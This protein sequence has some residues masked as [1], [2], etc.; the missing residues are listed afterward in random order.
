[1]R[2]LL[3]ISSLLLGTV[4]VG[5]AQE[6]IV[7]L[8]SRNLS[9]SEVCYRFSENYHI[10]FSFDADKLDNIPFDTVDSTISLSRFKA[11]LRSDYSITVNEVSPNNFYLIIDNT[12]ISFCGLVIDEFGL[13]LSEV[14]ILQDNL[15]IA[16]TDTLGKFVTDLPINTNIVIYADGMLENKVRIRDLGTD[17][18][19]I[20]LAMEVTQLD[21]VVVQEYLTKGMVKNEDSSIKLSPKD[22]GVLPGF[23]EPDIFQSLQRIP[24]VN[25]PT[26]DP[27]DLY[28]RGGTPD[29]NLVLYDGIKMYLND[30]FFKQISSYNPNIIKDVNVYRGGTSVRYGERISG[31]VDIKSSDDVFD[32]FKVGVGINLTSADAYLKIPLSDKLGILVAGRRSS[33]DLYKTFTYGKLAEKVFQ[34]SR[35]EVADLE[36]TNITDDPF[37]DYYFSDINFKT[38]WKPKAGHRLQFSFINISNELQTAN[39]ITRN[40]V[41]L[42]LDDLLIEKNLG[43]GFNW[44]NDKPGKTKKAFEAYFSSYSSAYAFNYD[45]ISDDAN[46]L[47]LYE[48]G[49]K[50][51][52]IG[53]DIFFDIPLAKKQSL[54]LGQQST[55]KVI[56]ISSLE[57]IEHSRWDEP[58]ERDFL[59]INEL[60]DLI[61]Y[62]E[63]KYKSDNLYFS[64]GLR[65]GLYNNYDDF[66]VE[67]RLYC[68]K[69]LTDKV[70]ITASAEIKNQSFSQ[71][72][73]PQSVGGLV[74]PLQLANN[75]WGIQ[76]VRDFNVA[77]LRSKQLTI[78]GLYDFNGWLVELEGYYKGISNALPYDDN[79]I[80]NLF[81]I[82]ERYDLRTGT[83]RRIG[84]DL[85]LKKRFR[86]YR[87]WLS[88]AYSVN[89]NKFAD[90]QNESFYDS[91][92]QRHNVNISQTYSYKKFEFGL[93]YSASSGLPFTEIGQGTRPELDLLI[94]RN[95][96]NKTR[97][98]EYYRW[99]IS[100]LYKF[101]LGEHFNGRA[102]F[103]ARNINNRRI[104]IKL[105]Y[106]LND[107]AG[108]DTVIQANERRSLGF[109]ADF[110]FRVNF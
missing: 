32:K 9:L 48:R 54:L 15:V 65:A 31:V 17:C 62:S 19:P 24:G 39:G 13:P 75:I 102:G 67:P 55:V 70:R 73:L 7:E 98:P 18:L 20:V 83:G 28:I 71:F 59:L 23:V 85:L 61:A 101:Q 100:A 46:A 30:H 106:A 84:M 25:S 69:K 64:F 22:L 80:P 37:V 79:F 45:Q 36:P 57:N 52:D 96:V 12:V 81:Q 95:E 68:S 4:A 104:P 53:Y 78:G 74:V 97:L 87:I 91:N 8:P 38:I 94:S 58:L 44:T 89:R 50:I 49:N 110:V 82:Q 107:T 35:L 77:I 5:L 34:N 11:I 40:N 33:T 42:K 103:A 109:I 26:E 63:Y 27:T 41:L 76:S 93:G 2:I 88:Y 51:I 56:D 108:D 47:F 92:A 6:H 21:E 14:S 3:L 10:K 99:D 43:I 72:Y 86:N 16:E 66:L 29:Q 105:D 90:V 1:M 60:L